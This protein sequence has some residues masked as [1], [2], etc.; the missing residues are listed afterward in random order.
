MVR[1][2]TL[3]HA[4]TTKDLSLFREVPPRLQNLI[5]ANRGE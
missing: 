5:D 1:G 3:S 4:Y 2:G